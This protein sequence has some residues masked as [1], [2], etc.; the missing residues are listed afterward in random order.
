MKRIFLSFMLSASVLLTTHAERTFTHPG[1]L[2][3]NTEIANM[4]RHIEAKEQPWLSEWN[5]LVSAYGGATYTAAANT[6]IGGSGGNRQRAC[7]D[8]QA[9]FFNALIYRV[10]GTK[11]NAICAAKI[12]SAW[13]NTC[14]SAK[15]ELFQFPCLDMCTAAEFLREEDG[16]FYT[17]WA[18]DDRTNFMTMVRDV[19]VPALRLL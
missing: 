6:E 5:A 12:L 4:K 7:R 3:S 8:A 10:R 19:F 18:E 14:V 15:E 13:G 17:G 1:A 11:S 16:S 9:A 2:V